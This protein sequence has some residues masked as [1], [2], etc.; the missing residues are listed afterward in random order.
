MGRVVTEGEVD[1]YSYSEPAPAE[2]ANGIQACVTLHLD[3]AHRCSKNEEWKRPRL[4]RL[5]ESPGEVGA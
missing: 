2:R 5:E 4:L 1:W 3:F